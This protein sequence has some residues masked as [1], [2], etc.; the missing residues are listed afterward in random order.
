MATLA[1]QIAS[2]GD[3]EPAAVL[4]DA[5]AHASVNLIPNSQ[6][7]VGNALRDLARALRDEAAA[8]EFKR[9]FDAGKPLRDE[10]NQAADERIAAE[11]RAGRGG[12]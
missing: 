3:L 2:D 5:A 11:T 6:V 12:R 4:L 7:H 9:Q 10:L 1:L 8:I